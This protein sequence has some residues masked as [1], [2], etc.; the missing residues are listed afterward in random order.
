MRLKQ[1][2]PSIDARFPYRTYYLNSATNLLTLSTGK[3]ALNPNNTVFL[4]PALLSSQTTAKKDCQR[5]NFRRGKKK[6]FP[7]LNECELP[8]FSGLFFFQVVFTATLPWHSDKTGKFHVEITLSISHPE[9]PDLRGA[10]GPGSHIV[11]GIFGCLSPVRPL[12]HHP[13]SWAFLSSPDEY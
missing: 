2:K 6:T 1:S 3:N 11:P 9:M 7:L 13:C 8:H 5:V 10:E 4:F 12:Y